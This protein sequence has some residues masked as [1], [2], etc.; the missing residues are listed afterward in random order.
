MSKAARPGPLWWAGPTDRLGRRKIAYDGRLADHRSPELHFGFDGWQGP[1]WDVRFE[2]G[3]AGIWL[4]DIPDVAGHLVIDCV[5]KAD[6]DCD[7]NH[8]ADYRLWVGLPPIDC[9]LHVMNARSDRMGSAALRIALASAGIA[10]G[11]VSWQANHIV[12]WLIADMPWLHQLVWV[13]PGR[14]P[15]AE[16]RR[17]LAAGHL[18][19]KLH[20]S[21][22]RFPADDPRLDQYLNLAREF[23]VPAA[24]HSAP[25]FAD[26]DLIRRLAD[27]F[28][29]VP[30][31]LY[32][33][34]LGPPEGRRRAARHAQQLSNLYL[35]TSWCGSDEVLRLI[36]EVGP[37]RVL[38]GSDAAVDGPEHF[39]RRPPN[40]QG[41][42]T[43]NGALL[44]IARELDR[45]TVHQVFRENT[46]RLFGLPGDTPA[47]AREP[48]IA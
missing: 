17:R 23:H 19:L 7:N 47:A 32:H 31:L 35:E 4:A 25:G 41:Q 43:Y 22:D 5:V 42:Q 39:V 34:Y 33:T 46:R 20:P 45:D 11:L 8:G 26:P 18:G 1:T 9:H 2:P 28:P 30:V 13:I 44:A 48:D 38:F 15:V 21:F 6:G 37:D 3:D 29:T 36:G 12:D 10:N 14:T 27:R 24:V 40:L 16:V